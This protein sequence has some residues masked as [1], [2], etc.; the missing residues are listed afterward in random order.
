VAATDEAVRLD[1]A[2]AGEL[3]SVKPRE[4]RRRPVHVGQDRCDAAEALD[5]ALNATLR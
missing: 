3:Q 2:A 1:V 5:W 4:E